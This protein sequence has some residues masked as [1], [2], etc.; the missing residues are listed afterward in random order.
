MK[1][2]KKIDPSKLILVRKK[3]QE[4]ARQEEELKLQMLAELGSCILENITQNESGMW[5]FL[6]GKKEE[7][8]NQAQRLKAALSHR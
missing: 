3:R 8:L 1:K 5:D 7:I 2:N 4:L 6:P